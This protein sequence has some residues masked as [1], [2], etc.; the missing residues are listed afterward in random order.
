MEIQLL[1]EQLKQRDIDRSVSALGFN[2]PFKVNEPSRNHTEQAEVISVVDQ[3]LPSG[4][5]YESFDNEALNQVADEHGE[6][7]ESTPEVTL[8]E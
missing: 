3:S 1:K 5:T 7:Y 4:L 8:E 6:G 2:K